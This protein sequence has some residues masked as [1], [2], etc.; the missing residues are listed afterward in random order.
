MADDPVI[1]T[2]K[3]NTH[4]LDAQKVTECKRQLDMPKHPIKKKPMKKVSK[5]VVDKHEA[6][7]GGEYADDSDTIQTLNDHIDAQYKKL[8]KKI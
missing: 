1:L 7:Y 2:I 5:I 6:I 8:T 4:Q 3:V